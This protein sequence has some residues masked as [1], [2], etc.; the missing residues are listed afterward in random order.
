MVVRPRSQTEE[1]ERFIHLFEMRMLA[2]L[3]QEVS[4]HSSLYARPTGENFVCIVICLHAASVAVRTRCNSSA[5]PAR[6]DWTCS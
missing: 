6:R 1:T 2:S 3:F 4:P 5:G